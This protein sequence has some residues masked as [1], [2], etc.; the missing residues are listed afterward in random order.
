MERAQASP[1]TASRGPCSALG[2]Q[3]IL[4]RTESSRWTAPYNRHVTKKGTHH[5]SGQTA[6]L[7]FRES[8]N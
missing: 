5:T 2:A 3:C 1:K 6:G 4:D 7:D 8:A